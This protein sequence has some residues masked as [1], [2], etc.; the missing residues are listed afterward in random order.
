MLRLRVGKF[1][2]VMNCF[3][4]IRI[5]IYFV[6]LDDLVLGVCC[7]FLNFVWF[8]VGFDGKVDVGMVCRN[9]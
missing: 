3:R 1:G 8:K 6:W 5:D 9:L 2:I 4:E 7:C